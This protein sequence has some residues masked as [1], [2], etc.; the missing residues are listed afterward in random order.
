MDGEMV[1]EFI[2][3]NP[4]AAAS[5]GGRL[6]TTKDDLTT[7]D[8]IKKLIYNQKLETWY[9]DDMKGLRVY[10]Y[11]FYNEDLKNTTMYNN[12]NFTRVNLWDNV[13]GEGGF[14]YSPK[15]SKIF[16]T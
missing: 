10:Q 1:G 14:W 3:T 16:S 2:N 7:M 9:D 6:N 13:M 8:F 5:S 15:T 12:W 4:E 11:C